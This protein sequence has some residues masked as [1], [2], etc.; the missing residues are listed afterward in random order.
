MEKLRSRRWGGG[1][2]ND[3]FAGQLDTLSF[4]QAIE[5]VTQQQGS[6]AAQLEEGMPDG[7][8]RRRELRRTEIVEAHHGKLLR[9]SQT[10]LP[11]SLDDPGGHIVV[12]RENRG[13]CVR[14]AP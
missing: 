11:A 5:L 7:G 4:P 2:T 6:L 8:E 3:Q 10:L 13:G 9:H 12:G 1:L 14:E